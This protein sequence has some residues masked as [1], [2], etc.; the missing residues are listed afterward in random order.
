MK[1]LIT[2]K[3]TGS[4]ILIPGSITLGALNYEVPESDYFNE[5]WKNAVEDGLVTKESHQ[6]DYNFELRREND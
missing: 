4:S 2:N 5:A 6:E 3:K 1:V